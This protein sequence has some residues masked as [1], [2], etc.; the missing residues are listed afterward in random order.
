VPEYLLHGLLPHVTNRKYRLFAAACGR[1]VLSEFRSER[2]DAERVLELVERYADGLASFEDI[3]RE[4]DVV[5]SPR[6]AGWSAV[7]AACSPYRHQQV[8]PDFDAAQ[9]ASRSVIGF[10]PIAWVKRN[11]GQRQQSKGAISATETAR[12]KV[13]E[14]LRCIVGNPFRSVGFDPRWR[15]ETVGALATGIYADRAFD[16]LPILADAL[17]EAGCDVAEILDHCRRCDGHHRGCWVMKLVLDRDPLP[18]DAFTDPEVIALL[19]QL[20]ESSPA[21]QLIRER[22]DTGGRPRPATRLPILFLLAPLGLLGLIGWWV[23]SQPKP[24]PNLNLFRESGPI[25]STP[26]VDYQKLVELGEQLTPKTRPTG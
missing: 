3:K 17:E 8:T 19:R 25:M 11:P 1:S 7:K 24:P 12:S 10:A 15:S 2:A 20:S 6:E 4:Y 9:W 22:L 18:V 21:T 16:R 13:V 23:A 14:L 26:T 5:R